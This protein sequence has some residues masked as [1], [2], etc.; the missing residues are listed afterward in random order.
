[1]FLISVFYLD[2]WARLTIMK[3]NENINKIEWKMKVTKRFYNFTVFSNFWFSS[4]KKLFW[5]YLI[6]VWCLKNG[7]DIFFNIELF[8]I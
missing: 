6:K 8:Y 3:R 1:M 5:M 7:F 4:Q 2:E